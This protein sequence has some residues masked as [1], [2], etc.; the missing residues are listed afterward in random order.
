MS[1]IETKNAVIK[2]ARLTT[3][4]Y[5]VL[6]GWIDLDY[7]GAGQ[8][9]GGHVLCTNPD[10]PF[11]PDKGSF[12]GIFIRRVMDVVGVTDWDKLPG[13]ACRVRAS[14]SHVEAI[15]NVIRDE[16]FEPEL[17]FASLK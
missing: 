1:D 6:S 4:D 13:K 5:G 8:G 17:E 10:S 3:V 2:S 7:G 14:R 9:F 15:G 12:G 11:Y 16:W